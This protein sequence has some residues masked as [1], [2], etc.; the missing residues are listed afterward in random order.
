MFIGHYGPAFAGK[1]I[2]PAIPLWLL[3]VAVQWMDYGWAILVLAGVEKFRVVPGFTEG[4]PLDLYY[5]PYT[6][7][8]LGALI[9]SALLGLLVAALRREAPL[10]VTLVVAAA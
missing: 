10:R 9:L 5:M 7:G 6:H 3:F 1:T 2:G 8:L 4:S